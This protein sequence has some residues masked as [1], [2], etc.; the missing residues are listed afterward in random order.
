M[1]N[2]LSGILK[3]AKLKK[4]LAIIVKGNPKYINN[5][6]IMPIAKAFYKEIE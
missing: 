1:F 6:A 4:P 5:P 2:Q 3:A